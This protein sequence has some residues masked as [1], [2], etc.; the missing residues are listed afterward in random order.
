MRYNKFTEE[1]K[2]GTGLKFDEHVSC[3][4]SL[5]K[6]VHFPLR[7][8]KLKLNAAHRCYDGHIYL[9]TADASLV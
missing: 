5:F 2:E 3:I 6:K 9:E 4:N 7:P 8:P 1:V